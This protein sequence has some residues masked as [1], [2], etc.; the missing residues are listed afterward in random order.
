MTVDEKS[1]T[2][3]C[4]TADRIPSGIPKTVAQMMPLSAIRMEIGA[5]LAI[6]L[7]TDVPLR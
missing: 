3:Y 5:R 1:N 6:S 4:F 2:E 7:M